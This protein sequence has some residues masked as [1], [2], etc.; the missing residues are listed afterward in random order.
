M[1]NSPPRR[2]IT[3]GQAINLNS[4]NRHAQ[5]SSGRNSGSIKLSARRSKSSATI[6]V[7]STKRRAEINKSPDRSWRPS[8]QPTR[9]SRVVPVAG[10]VIACLRR[11][12][13]PYL[14]A[15]SRPAATR[16]GSTPALFPSLSDCPESP[17][18]RAQMLEK[19]TINLDRCLPASIFTILIFTQT[20]Q[21]A[22]E[23]KC[24]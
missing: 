15:L 19:P 10:T 13:Q 5:L 7:S 9:S 16:T 23:S 11:H 1:K 2:A 8:G 3:K 20:K 14:R 4:G 21:A 22:M 6:F 12:Q 17:A 18:S 24:Q